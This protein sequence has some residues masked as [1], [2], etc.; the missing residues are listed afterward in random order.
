MWVWWFQNF[1]TFFFILV[2][3]FLSVCLPIKQTIRTWLDFSWIEL[4]QKD[5]FFTWVCCLWT[6]KLWLSQLIQ[7]VLV[8][9]FCIWEWNYSTKKILIWNVCIS[10]LYALLHCILWQLFL[11]LGSI[12]SSVSVNLYK[13]IMNY[14][15]WLRLGI[16]LYNLY[17]LSFSW[18]ENS[19]RCCKDLWFW[20]CWYCTANHTYPQSKSTWIHKKENKSRCIKCSVIQK[21]LS[22]S[23]LSVVREREKRKR[24]ER[25]VFCV[26][27]NDL[28]IQN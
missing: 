1:C 9:L 17:F 18:E 7:F 11:I 10:Y 3:V 24:I 12:C 25:V 8:L 2:T 20:W 27:K 26:Y 23:T 16:F 14:K 6:V 5:L 4:G 21:D 22:K 19:L 13:K 15:L 28:Q